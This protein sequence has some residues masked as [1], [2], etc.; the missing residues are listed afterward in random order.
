MANPAGRSND[1]PAPPAGAAFPLLVVSLKAKRPDDLADFYAGTLGLTLESRGEGAVELR[2]GWTVLRFDR[3]DADGPDPVYHFAFNIPHNR[4]DE[5]LAWM[6]ERARVTRGD[7]GAEVHDFAEWDAR[8][9]YFHDPAGNVVEFIARRALDNSTDHAFTGADIGELSEIGIVSDDVNRTVDLA[10]D[11]FGV[12]PFVGRRFD[13][14]TALGDAHGLL[15][16]VAAGRRWLGSDRIAESFPV[17]ITTRGLPR[18]W[19]RFAGL[20]VEIERA[21]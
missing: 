1:R 14:F 3:C 10:M 18:E 8:A 12:R 17:R 4:L 15:I 19:R 20:P 6:R 2:A 16:V 5:A 21:G 13:E 9:F 11:Q 7:D